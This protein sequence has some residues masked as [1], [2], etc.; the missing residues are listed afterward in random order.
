MF[1]KM[2][3]AYYMAYAVW[4]FFTTKISYNLLPRPAHRKQFEYK[5]SQTDSNYKPQLS[6]LSQILCTTNS[7]T[8][9]PT[10][11]RLTAGQ[12]SDVRTFNCL[13]PLGDLEVLGL[14]VAMT[15]ISG[16]D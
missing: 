14:Y 1:Q 11:P 15:F 9:C 7:Q 16:L 3:I 8:L 12:L 6:P 4:I 5:F 2:Y 13:T 10:I